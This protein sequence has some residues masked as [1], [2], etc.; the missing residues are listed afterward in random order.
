M[1]NEEEKSGSLIPTGSWISDLSGLGRPA[2]AL[3]EYISKGLGRLYL[4]RAIR[5][6][7]KARAEVDTYMA[8]AEAY[9]VERLARAEVAKKRILETE[10]EGL[11]HR[12]GLRVRDKETTRQYNLEQTVST[13]LAL[14]EREDPEATV[15]DISQDWI[16]RYLDYVEV[17]SDPDIQMIWA[18]ILARKVA[19]RKRSVSLMTLDSLRLIEFD[20]AVTF[21]VVGRCCATFGS[22][23]I[24]SHN[25]S[26]MNLG[27]NELSALEAL[28]FIDKRPY[29]EFAIPLQVGLVLMAQREPPKK[30]SRKILE[31]APEYRLTFRGRE[32][33]GVI[34]P[35]Y[36]HAND[37]IT[38]NPYAFLDAERQAR[39][40]AEWAI[41]YVSFGLEPTII[42]KL[43][44]KEDINRRKK[45]LPRF[46]THIW[47]KQ[48]EGW[49]CL[50]DAEKFETPEIIRLFEISET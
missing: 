38:A 3:I 25:F 1:S 29:T 47:D 27:V 42:A 45:G 12:A 17:V 30:Q 33:A 35:Q 48:A 26:S 43:G 8:D 41:H 34:I 14:V 5:E 32:L 37:L 36:E 44:S 2:T 9:R 39:I 49:R 50:P 23:I 10:G 20:H 18:R 31:G 46:A 19:D 15:E 40:L 13:A 22:I 16:D 4:P 24:T 11:L 7:G 28:G 21:D 6:E